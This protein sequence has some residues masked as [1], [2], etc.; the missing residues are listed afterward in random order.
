MAV[1]WWM[2]VNW[3]IYP[4]TMYPQTIP[5]QSL[6]EG[7]NT[8]FHSANKQSSVYCLVYRTP[9]TIIVAMRHQMLQCYIQQDKYKKYLVP[10]YNKGMPQSSLYGITL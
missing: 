7:L 4:Q 6:D 5:A 10:E 2:G 3:W 1:N 8:H 9:Y